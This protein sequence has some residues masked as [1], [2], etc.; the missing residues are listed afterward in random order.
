MDGSTLVAGAV[1]ESES[2]HSMPGSFEWPAAAALGSSESWPVFVLP[3]PLTLAWN[4]VTAPA[5]WIFGVYP[6]GD[7]FEP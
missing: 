2:M 4:L 6:Y 1:R 3:L 5:P 7:G